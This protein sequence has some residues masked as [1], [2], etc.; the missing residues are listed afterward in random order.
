MASRSVSSAKRSNRLDFYSTS[1]YPISPPTHQFNIPRHRLVI[2]TKCFGL[3][4]DDPTIISFIRPDLRDS[5]REY[6]NQ[7]GL[8]RAAIF[9]Q[10]EGSL[11]RLDTSYIDLYQIHRSDLNNV[12][13]EV[14]AGHGSFR[15]VIDVCVHVGDDESSARP[16]YQWQGSL[17]R[18][19]FDVGVGVST[20]QPRCR[21]GIT[22]ILPSLNLLVTQGDF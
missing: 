13:A 21:K 11:A 12:P 22:S 8:S 4:A 14:S 15:K 10:V 5:S 19:V 20:L 18:S 6:V 16:C 2:L 17:H 9:N 1:V 7:S 3:V